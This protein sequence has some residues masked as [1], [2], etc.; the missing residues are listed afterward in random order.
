[1]AYPSSGVATSNQISATIKMGGA[2]KMLK[3]QLSRVL[4]PGN[5]LILF[6]FQAALRAHQQP[7]KLSHSLYT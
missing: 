1:M 7:H 2:Y 6:T 3:G 4:W 5:C